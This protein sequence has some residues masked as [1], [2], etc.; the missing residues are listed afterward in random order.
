MTG[1]CPTVGVGIIP[2]AGIK[3]VLK[4]GK[5]RPRRS[6]RCR[7]RLPCESLGKSGASAVLVAAQVSVPGIVSPAGIQKGEEVAGSSRPRRSF[8]CRST[9]PC[10]E[11]SSRRALSVVVVAVQLFGAGIISAAGIGN[12]GSVAV[13]PRRSFQCR[14]T[15]PCEQTGQRA[16]RDA[17]SRPTVR[18]GIV[19]APGV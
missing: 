15:L 5:T 16:C 3:N 11:V 12:A 18:T 8:H 13:R 2:P 7:S 14:S 10:E 9:L 6:F 19:S 17:G 4:A 1:R